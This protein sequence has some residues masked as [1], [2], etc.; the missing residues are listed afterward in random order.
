MRE[1]GQ[2]IEIDLNE[3]TQN[4]SEAVKYI[5][6]EKLKKVDRENSRTDTSILLK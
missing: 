3:R 4:A 5:N 2:V 6:K 1:L